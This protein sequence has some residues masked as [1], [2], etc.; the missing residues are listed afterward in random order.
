MQLRLFSLPV[1]KILNVTFASRF[2]GQPH[3]TFVNTC[4]YK[5]VLKKSGGPIP[6][7]SA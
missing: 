1:R 7:E 4:A 2:H 6:V 5:R 3:E